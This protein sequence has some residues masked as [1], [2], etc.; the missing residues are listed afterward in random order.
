MLNQ[1]DGKSRGAYYGLP[2]KNQVNHCIA[3]GNACV[4]ILNAE[5]KEGRKL[6]IWNEELM[7]TDNSGGGSNYTRL[8]NHSSDG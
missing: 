5:R 2:L 7:R 3:V 1:K 4:K 6:K 8:T